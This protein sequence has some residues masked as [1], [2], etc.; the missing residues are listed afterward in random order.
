VTP[1][2]RGRASDDHSQRYIGSPAFHRL[3]AIFRPQAR[4]SRFGCQETASRRLDPEVGESTGIL[5]F[6]SPQG[7]CLHH[8]IRWGVSPPSRVGRTLMSSSESSPGRSS[9]R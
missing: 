7:A 8:M 9:G 3:E 2:V 5:R 6:I 4:Y 1:D